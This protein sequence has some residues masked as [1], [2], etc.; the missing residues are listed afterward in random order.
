MRFRFVIAAGV[1]LILL[2]V[3]SRFGLWVLVAMA[4]PSA[5][6]VHH[7][8]SRALR[9]AVGA[10][11]RALRD[12]TFDDLTAIETGGDGHAEYPII[13]PRVAE[14][15]VQVNRSGAD[16]LRIVVRGSMDVLFYTLVRLDG[17]YARPGAE[18]WPMKDADFD[19]LE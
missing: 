1:A 2:V 10:K 18:R 6:L 19:A 9:T 17:F 14:L 16:T 12:L 7:R 13:G 3:A 4:V 15:E 11:S 5:L 8:A